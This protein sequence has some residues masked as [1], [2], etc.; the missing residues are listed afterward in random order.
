MI[1]VIPKL[2]NYHQGRHNSGIT[3]V[4]LWSIIKSSRIFHWNAISAKKLTAWNVSVFGA[5]LVRIF[6]YLN[7]IWR[8]TEYLSVFSPNVE[9][10]W[11]EKLRTLFTQWLL[12]IWPYVLKKSLKETFIFGAVLHN[13]VESWNIWKHPS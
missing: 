1:N 5:F 7:W 3:F 13:T 10:Y 6:K 2:G 9:K 4:L 11:P 12:R 8:D